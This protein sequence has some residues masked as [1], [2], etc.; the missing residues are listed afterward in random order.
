MQE[1]GAV[2]G[3]AAVPGSAHLANVNG[4]FETEA[5]YGF[6]GDMRCFAARQAL[7]GDARRRSGKS[8]DRRAFTAAGDRSEDGPES[9]TTARELGC[10]L[11]LAKSFPALLHEVAGF[12]P[13]SSATNLN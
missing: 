5:H 7:G 1:G 3:N 12:H 2:S 13:I 6:G 8:A 4:R 9:R 11:V 10:T